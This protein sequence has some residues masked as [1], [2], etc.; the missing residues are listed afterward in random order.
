MIATYLTLSFRH[1]IDNWFDK[2]LLQESMDL[3]QELLQVEPKSDND[4]SDTENVEDKNRPVF[5]D[6]CDSIVVE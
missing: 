1:I 5:A 2:E 3:L 4:H 6:C